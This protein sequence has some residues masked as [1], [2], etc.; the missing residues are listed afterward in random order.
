MGVVSVRGACPVGAGQRAGIRTRYGNRRCPDARDRDQAAAIIK[1]L[2]LTHLAS[3]LA[4]G[5]AEAVS[6]LKRGH[7]A[8]QRLAARWAAYDARNKPAT[9][10]NAA[11]A[12]ELAGWCWSLAVLE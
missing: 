11:I 12:R 6:A 10:A 4:P 5:V 9:V 2:D 3:D 7:A 8:N 1:D